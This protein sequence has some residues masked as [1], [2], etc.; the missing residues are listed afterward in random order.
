VHFLTKFFFSTLGTIAYVDL[1]NNGIYEPAIGDFKYAGGIPVV[2]YNN[3]TQQNTTTTDSTGFY[4]FTG[5]Y[6]GN[7]R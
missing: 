5:L 1:N 2:L 6:A 4:I 3:G 7:Y